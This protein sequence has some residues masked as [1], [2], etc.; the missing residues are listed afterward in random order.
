MTSTTVKS[1]SKRK[2]KSPANESSESKQFAM[3]VSKG[4]AVGTASL[5]VIL[6]I[7]S[8]IMVKF[9]YSEKSVPIMALVSALLAA[10]IAGFWAAKCIKKKGL[11]IGIVTSLPLAIVMITFVI[12]ANG[13]AVG[14]LAVTTV[15]LMI[16][17]GGLGGIMS[18]NSKAKRPK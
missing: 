15:L 13:G 9:D 8:L 11:M 1:K 10:F 17:L 12:I 7:F 2:T 16:C 3:A 5:F 4:F 14:S 6:S 18:V